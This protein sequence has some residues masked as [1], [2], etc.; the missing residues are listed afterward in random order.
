MGEHPTLQDIVLNACKLGT[1][2]ET[3]L[4][5]YEQTIL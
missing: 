2:L 1:T 3:E 5:K 4:S